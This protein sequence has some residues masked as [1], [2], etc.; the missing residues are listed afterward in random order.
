M[1]DG[2]AFILNMFTSKCMNVIFKND[3]WGNF[4]DLPASSPA[5]GV[6]VAMANDLPP[7]MELCIQS[8]VVLESVGGD[9][10]SK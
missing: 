10:C 6:S 5:N 1:Y 4:N 3:I 9:G 7:A 2:Y 8:E